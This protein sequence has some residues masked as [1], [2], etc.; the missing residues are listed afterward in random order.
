M[1]SLHNGTLRYLT[2]SLKHFHSSMVCS[3]FQL[4]LKITSAGLDAGP[5][6]AQGA[7]TCSPDLL[8]LQGILVLLHSALWSE[9]ALRMATGSS[10]KVFCL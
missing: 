10:A 8:L 4:V 5:H 2:L 7:A 6:P 1:I 3:L 9:T